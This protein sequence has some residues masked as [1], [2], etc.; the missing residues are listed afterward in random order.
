[1][2]RIR[3]K[4]L[5]S[6]SQVTIDLICGKPECQRQGLKRVLSEDHL[7]IVVR[8]QDNGA[9]ILAC[10]LLHRST[11]AD[12]PG[13]FF[14]RWRNTFHGN[15]GNQVTHGS[16]HFC[17]TFEVWKTRSESDPSIGV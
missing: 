7:R 11:D 9:S 4:E 14:A 6:F 10:L 12:D 15:L 1:V 17:Q 2:I 8:R 13:E 3:I 5:P 16:Y